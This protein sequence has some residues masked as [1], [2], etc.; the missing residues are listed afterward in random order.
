VLDGLVSGKVGAV[1]HVQAAFVA[2]EAGFL[3]DVLLRQPG[4]LDLADGAEMKGAGSAAAF[5]QRQHGALAAGASLAALGV[6]APL[7][8]GRHLR[9]FDVAEIGL[10]NLD[11][12]AVT[13]HRGKAHG[14]HCMT[15]TMRHEP[16]GFQG[17]AKGAVKLVGADAL[18][19]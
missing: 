11:H 6:W 4:N 1:A 10:V 5:D 7:P 19:A 16:G 2:V 12:L 17:D 14:L 3:G 15:D 8:L 13:T 9:V 18:L